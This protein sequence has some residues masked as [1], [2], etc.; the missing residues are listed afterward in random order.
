MVWSPAVSW[1][2]TSHSRWAT[3]S[4]T[5]GALTFL[6]GIGVKFAFL[7]LSKLLP[8]KEPQATTACKSSSVGM[9]TI[10]SPDSA[11]RVC[12]WRFGER[13]IAKSGGSLEVGIAHARVVTLGLPALPTHETRTVCIG[14]RSLWA[15]V[16]FTWVFAD[17]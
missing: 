16:I 5:A 15:V 8:V 14:C 9:L 1:S 4:R 11:I 3:H 12:E 2:S 7:N 10:N 13:L 17:T 6:A